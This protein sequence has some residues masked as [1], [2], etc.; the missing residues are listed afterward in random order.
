[1]FHRVRRTHAEC[2]RKAP[3]DCSLIVVVCSRAGAHLDMLMMREP[4]RGKSRGPQP[5]LLQSPPALSKDQAQLQPRLAHVYLAC[6]PRHL[7]TVKYCCRAAFISSMLC[8]VSSCKVP[9]LSRSCD[10]K[11]SAPTQISSR[12]HSSHQLS[13]FRVYIRRANSL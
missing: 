1:L 3:P 8:T 9:H 6:E 11:V 4:S 2:R 10:F 7:G 13:L 12:S 5:P